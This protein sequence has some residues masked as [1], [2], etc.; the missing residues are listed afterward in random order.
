[1][2]FLSSGFVNAQAEPPYSRLQQ[3]L[4]FFV[5][6]APVLFNGIHNPILASF[7]SDSALWQKA[8]VSLK[9][10]PEAA[11]KPLNLWLVKIQISEWGYCDDPDGKVH[12]VESEF[13]NLSPDEKLAVLAGCASRDVFK[14]KGVTDSNRLLEYFQES[15]FVTD[16]LLKLQHKYIEKTL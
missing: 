4:S 15:E 7:K 9:F 14:N 16:Q 1:M 2:I 10:T 6:M 3:Q 12:V 5:R 8:I 13:T 11:E